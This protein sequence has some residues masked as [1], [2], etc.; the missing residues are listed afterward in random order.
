MNVSYYS[1]TGIT[2]NWNTC[3]IHQ[4]MLT[5]SFYIHP[6]HSF[7][8]IAILAPKSDIFEQFCH[9]TTHM[10]TYLLNGLFPEYVLYMKNDQFFALFRL[11]LILARFDEF[12]FSLIVGP[13]GM[14]GEGAL[15]QTG[16]VQK[17][18]PAINDHDT[19]IY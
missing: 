9:V 15:A 7:K 11:I 19:T 12:E 18:T 5:R 8:E 3:L 16:G 14:L 10:W 2:G 13:R 4:C 1:N 17:G 6:V